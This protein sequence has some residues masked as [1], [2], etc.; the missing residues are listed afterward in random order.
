MSKQD[1]SDIGNSEALASQCQHHDDVEETRHFDRV[2]DSFRQYATFRKAARDGMKRRIVSL[3]IDDVDRSLLPPSLLPNT[4]E[5]KA[6]EALLHVAGNRNQFFFDSMLRYAGLDISQD[7]LRA[8]ASGEAP[9]AWST[10]D[11]MSKVDSVLKSLARDWSSEG[12]AERS[13]AYHPIIEGIRAHLPVEIGSDASSPRIAV[14]GSGVG[15]LAWDLVSERY[16]VQGSDFSLHML[17]ASDFILNGTKEHSFGISP[18]LSETKNVLSLEKRARTVLVPDIDPTSMAKRFQEKGAEP[19]FAMHAGEFVSLYSKPEEVGQ[20]NAIA[21]CFFLDT[22]PCITKYVRVMYDMLEEGGIIVNFGPLLYHWSG[23]GALRPDDSSNEKYLGR[24]EHLEQR[25]LESI[26]L[27]WEEVRHVIVAC[28]FEIVEERI[29][30]PAKY[31]SDS[32]SFMSVCYDCVYFVAK[33]VKRFSEGN[34]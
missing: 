1:S 33:K 19:D 16:A 10:E 27:T 14:P 22:A 26:D 5:G 13:A 21:S 30:I 2:C 31:T 11:D 3:S 4:A 28:G 34:K 8:H 20:W 23:H 7:A 9:I 12:A 15:R 18:W 6:R 32:D 25:Y 29:G 17:M 24:N